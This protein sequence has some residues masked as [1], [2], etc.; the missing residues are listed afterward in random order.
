MDNCSDGCGA[1]VCREPVYGFFTQVGS[2]N[3][4][5]GG[6]VP[7]NGGSTV[8][9]I[10]KDG[11]SLTLDEEGVYLVTLS[12][13][14]P[15]NTALYTELDVR[16]NGVG[17]PGGTLIVDKD[18]ATDPLQN[19]IQT[20]ITVSA[21]AVVTVTSSAAVN[22]TADSASAPIVTLTLVKIS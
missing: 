1:C 2:L 10:W 21:G 5:A 9:N 3:I 7:F 12:A 13:D 6:A 22:L 17:T 15:A 11:G 16:V 8:E 14:I 19:S 4:A 18:V 20:V